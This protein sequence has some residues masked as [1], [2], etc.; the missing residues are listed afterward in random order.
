MINKIVP[1]L[2]DAV[3]PITDG[4]S[5]MV[6]GFG[7]SGLP[8]ELLDALVEHG[9]KDLT[10]IS[11]NAGTGTNG[12]AALLLAGRVRKVICSYPKSSGADVFAELYKAKRVELELVPQGTLIERMRAAGAGLGPFFTP[13]GYGT[14]IAQGKEQREYDGKGYVLEVPLHA[15]FALVKACHADRWGNLTWRLASRGFGPVMCMA[16]KH[17]IAQVDDIVPL[18]AIAPESVM[19]PGI[20]IEA[21]VQKESGRGR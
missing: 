13:T 21:I 20:F 15:D 1:T 6:A 16:A 11:N 7:D 10:I 9:T 12:L 18:G 5:V 19:T 17:A 2:R 8:F 4:A 14:P 3:A